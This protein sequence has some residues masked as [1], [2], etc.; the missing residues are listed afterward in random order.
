MLYR[1]AVRLR[2]IQGEPGLQEPRAT[3]QGV[4]DVLRRLCPDIENQG[5]FA[6]G[7][8]VPPSSSHDDLPLRTEVE[9]PR[10]VVASVLTNM[11]EREDLQR[12]SAPENEISA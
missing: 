10:F 4:R 2:L 12:I 11:K 5:R 6:L 9:N 3:E 1:G 7:G 8:R